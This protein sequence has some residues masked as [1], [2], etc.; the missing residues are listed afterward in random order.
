MST[1]TRAVDQLQAV[2]MDSVNT[3]IWNND[4]IF[5]Q[6]VFNDSSDLTKNNAT[7]RVDSSSY[8]SFPVSVLGLPGNLFVIAVYMFKMT[9]STRVYMFALAVADS[10]VCISGMVLTFAALD[11]VKEVV[12]FFI[13]S[14]SATFSIFLLVLVSIERLIAVKRPHSFNIEPQRAKK[15]TLIIV[16]PA[17]LFAT[18]TET[19][20][21]MRYIRFV[22]VFELGMLFSCAFIIIICYTLMAEELLNKIRPSRNQVG[23]QSVTRSTV[24][25]TSE[26]VISTIADPGHSC[27]QGT[28]II[29]TVAQ[30]NVKSNTMK[31]A[32][33][34][35]TNK[36]TA[37][38]TKTFKSV[39][40][41][42]I[43]TTTFIA[44]WLPLWL[45]NMGVSIPPEWIGLFI[46]NSVVNPFIYGVASVMFREDVRQ[47]YRQTRVKLSACCY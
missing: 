37:K 24:P 11:F 9:T 46:L 26:L 1:S 27:N 45:S 4:S 38:Q 16:V 47:F 15:A 42:F 30:A 5:V 10:A 6:N 21:A 25:R 28:I 34:T 13:I 39:F 36:I 44:C 23:V 8:V 18:V 29:P 22:E 19:L 2:N 33:V 17:T 31:S 12:F 3:S 7:Q 35:A 32:P 41:L 43:I 40:L 20:H 14:M